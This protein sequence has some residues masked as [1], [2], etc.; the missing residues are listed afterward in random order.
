MDPPP[1][2]G[3]GG[4]SWRRRV[5]GGLTRPRTPDH[6]EDAD[7]TPARPHRAGRCSHA[8]GARAGGDEPRRRAVPGSQGLRPGRCRPGRAGRRPRRGARRARRVLRGDDPGV[9]RPAARG[10][11]APRCPGDRRPHPHPAGRGA[12]ASGADRAGTWRGAGPVHARHPGRRGAGRRGRRAA[13]QDRPAGAGRLP[14]RRRLRQRLGAA[15]GP[16]AVGLRRAHGRPAR[17]RVVAALRLVRPAGRAGHVQRAHR[18]PRDGPRPA[19]RRRRAGTARPPGRD[20]AGPGGGRRRL[21][22]GCPRRC[23]E[24]SARRRRRRAGAGG[25]GARAADRHLHPAAG[26]AGRRQARRDLGAAGSRDGATVP[27]RHGTL[28][29]PARG[30][31]TSPFGMRV[32]PVTGVYKLHTGTDLGDP[33][34]H[35]RARVPAP[36]P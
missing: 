31:V 10:P 7:A 3:Q 23:P 4:R 16:L 1:V 20:P 26:P 30:P 22:R 8:R 29:W 33:V 6:R 12:E 24:G 18:R 9:R 28:G 17:R 5:W 32:H 35:R 2:T 15:R 21:A 11:G 13:G 19:G 14:G 25:R 34:R 36:A 27:T